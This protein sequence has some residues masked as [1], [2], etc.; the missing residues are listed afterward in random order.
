MTRSP[1]IFLSMFNV[2]LVSGVAWIGITAHKIH[3]A[4][5]AECESRGGVP[6]VTIDSVVVCIDASRIII[7]R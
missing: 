6:I 3:T 2:A 7:S 4:L 1:L 5:K